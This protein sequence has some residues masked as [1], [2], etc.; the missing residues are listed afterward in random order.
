MT[1]VD[2]ALVVLVLLLITGLTV[3]R[4]RLGRPPEEPAVL[5]SGRRSDRNQRQG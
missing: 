4:Y 5:E 1:G 3:A 2:I